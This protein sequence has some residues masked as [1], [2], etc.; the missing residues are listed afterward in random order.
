MEKWKLISRHL[1]YLW[2]AK[3]KYQIHSPFVFEFTQKVL[4]DDRVFYVFEE[5]EVLRAAL[6]KD[7]TPIQKEDFGAGSM[8][9][10]TNQTSVAKI[11][12]F[13]QSQ[14]RVGQ[15]LFR[16]TDWLKPK[17][18]VE[19]GTALG[20]TT[21]YQAKGSMD[22]KMYSIEGCSATAAVARRVIAEGDVTNV[23]VREGI[24]EE[25]LPKLLAEVKSV[26]YVFIDGNH[27]KA[28]TIDYFEKCLPYVHND[29]VIVFDDVRWSEGMA[30]AW[31]T[32]KA[33]PKVTLTLEVY[34]VGMVFFRAEQKEKEHF[35]L[36]P[37]KYKPLSSIFGIMN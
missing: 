21:M 35:S 24:F 1:K 31:A 26:D 11:A 9:V 27:R 25:V 33:H 7:D 18:M 13:N 16:L 34:D 4:E 14:P 32:I 23:E 30:E 36:L 3:T 29:T 28:P 22:G 17:V 6:K 19:L 15:V 20:V 5:L 37:A 12:R 10:G 8:I 2:R